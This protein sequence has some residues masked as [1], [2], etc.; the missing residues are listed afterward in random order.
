MM[1]DA[2]RI[3]TTASRAR[4]HR[5]RFYCT[6]LFLFLLTAA[7]YSFGQEATIVGTVTDPS[8]ASVAGAVV[9]V[10]HHD[11]GQVHNLTTGNAGEYVASDIHI[12]H[13]TV[14]VEAKGFKAEERRDLLLQVGDRARLDFQMQLGATQETITVEATAV[15]VQSDTSEISEVVTGDQLAHLGTNGRSVYTFINLTPGS[16]SL[17]GDSQSPTPVG[18]DA[19]VSF[20]GNRPVHNLYL[21]DGGE[22]ADRGGG[23]TTA[24]M[25]SIESMAEFRTLTSN[26]DAEYGLSSAATMTSVLRSGTKQYHASAWEFFRNDALQSRNYFNPAPQKI[27]ELRYNIFGFNAGGPIDF[28]KKEHKSFFFYN[29]EWRRVIQGQTLTQAVPLA[30]EYPDAGGANTG[31]VFPVDP[32]LKQFSI[33]DPLLTVVP[34]SVQFANCPGGVAPAGV[35]PGAQFLNNTIPDC[36]IAANASALLGAGIFPKPNNGLNFQGGANQPTN[37]REEIVR[38]DHTF[39]DKFTIFGHFVDE[40]VLQTFGTTMWSGDNVPT[41]GNTFG[42][43]SYSGVVHLIHTIRPNLLNEVAF[44]YNANRI[45]IIPIGPVLNIPTGF[46]S[47]PVFSGP[48]LGHIPTINLNGQTGA[49]YSSNWTPWINKY[50]DYQ[51]R[52]DISWTRGAH[53][54]KMG[55]S[56]A[57]YKK[58]QDVFAATQGNFGFNGSFT[59]N[60]VP[61]SQGVDFADYLLG[62]SQQYQEDAVHDHGQWNNVSWAAYIQD[63]WRVNRKLTLNLGLRWDGVPHTYEANH[64]TSNFYPNLFQAPDAATFFTDASDT[65]ISP[66]GSAVPYLGP[67]PNPILAGSQFYLNGIGVGGLHGIPNGLVQNHWAA[68][69][70]RIGFAYDLS[71][72]GKTVIRGGF[73]LMYERIQGNDMYNAGTNVPF[74][75]SV[76]LNNVLLANPNISAASGTH[77]PA[78]PIVVPSITGVS[79]GSYRLPTSAQYSFSLEQ[80]L[81]ARAVL[82]VAYVGNQNRHQSDYR[83]INLAPQSVLPCQVDP[84]TYCENAPPAYNGLVP[85]LGYHSLK[86]A[87]DEANSHYNSLQTSV[88]GRL[89]RDLELQAGY[90]LSKAMDPTT[91][92]GNGFDLDPVSNPYLGWKA[93]MGPSIFDRRNVL[94]LSFVYDI[95]LF[96]D[97]SNRLAKAALGGWQMSGIVTLMSGAPLNITV[98]GNSAASIVPNVT[99]RPNVTGSISYP[100]KPTEW[101]DPSVFTAP[102]CAT[103]PD[104]FGNLG[105]DALRGPGRDN[106]NMS[107]FKNFNFTERTRLEFRVDA[108][109]L[110]NH[111]QFVGNVQQGGIGTQVGGSNF[112]SFT[113]ASDPRTLQL[114]LKMVF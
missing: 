81:G 84:K 16:S 95:P 57:L 99:V 60:G 76:T 23:G 100:H 7:L 107:L 30:S 80:A 42:N 12:G 69:G 77:V 55:A 112:G 1:C 13:Y 48:P 83:E 25:P 88:R 6:A 79:S 74:S 24:V 32:A 67:S 103:G 94:F 65:T 47:N 4:A 37:V 78:L 45:N 3:L 20:N 92:G 17:Q 96:R 39:N 35:T 46:Q 21:I 73:G 91:G 38:V 70:P 101:F 106:W 58:Q 31:A 105:H 86:L 110:W 50:D 2:L 49:Q 72:A 54:F 22:D 64:R 82:S 114:G 102:A 59:A 56:W 9:T 40:S 108:F 93:D 104:C 10:T 52:D 26:Y 44:N 28:W 98:N 8:G 19:N 85:Y 62:Y 113:S 11:T 75:A 51:I 29:M 14:R 68:F 15:A 41:T 63:N 53:Q 5:S 109:N 66:T 111:T 43:P 33:F 61:A 36:M 71:G 87:F 18:G 27:A 97:N 90:T 89:A 34:A